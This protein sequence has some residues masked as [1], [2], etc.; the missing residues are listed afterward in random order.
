MPS[1]DREHSGRVNNSS[2]QEAQQDVTVIGPREGVQTSTHQIQAT[3]DD[4]SAP[5][6]RPRDHDMVGTS[7][8]L[9]D[10]PQVSLNENGTAYFASPN[11]ASQDGSI[12]L[13]RPNRS[14]ARV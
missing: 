3:D 11:N 2:A 7:R 6:Q 9:D 14:K 8:H 12:R 4:T 10:P 1:L 13:V 5:D